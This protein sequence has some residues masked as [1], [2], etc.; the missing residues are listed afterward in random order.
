MRPYAV[1]NIKPDNCCFLEKYSLL[2]KY[3]LFFIKLLFHAK[4]RERTEDFEDRFDPFDRAEVTDP[5]GEGN[6]APKPNSTK[7]YVL[8]IVI[9]RASQAN[10]FFL[11]LSWI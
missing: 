9:C 8:V 4:S 2:Y 7:I 3:I 11:E 1:S 10:L 5:G 6:S